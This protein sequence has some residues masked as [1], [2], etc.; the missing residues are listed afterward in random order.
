MIRN[1]LN[2]PVVRRLINVK[3]DVPKE[4]DIC[5]DEVNV[6]YIRT[7]E[8]LSKQYMKLLQSN[9]S[10]LVVLFCFYCIPR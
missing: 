8:D 9:V 1:Y 10:Q 4:W 2:S 6:K 5:S 3:P 7:Y